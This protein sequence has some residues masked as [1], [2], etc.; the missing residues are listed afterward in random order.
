MNKGADMAV[1]TSLKNYTNLKA[2]FGYVRQ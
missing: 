2:A 1:S